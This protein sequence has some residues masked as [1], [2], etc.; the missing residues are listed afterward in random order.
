MEDGHINDEKLFYDRLW[1]PVDPSGLLRVHCMLSEAD[2][3]SQLVLNGDH[4]NAASIA[5]N[6]VASYRAQVDVVSTGERMKFQEISADICDRLIVSEIAS[7]KGQRVGEKRIVTLMKEPEPNQRTPVETS[8]DAADNKAPAKHGFTIVTLAKSETTKNDID[9][10]TYGH[11]YDQF[12]RIALGDKGE[13]KGATK[14]NA[15]SHGFHLETSA[16][17]NT[18]ADTA[19]KH[20]LENITQK[21]KRIPLVR[22]DCDICRRSCMLVEDSAPGQQGPNQPVPCPHSLGLKYTPEPHGLSTMCTCK[23]TALER[24]MNEYTS[25]IDCP[26]HP[27]A[28]KSVY[29]TSTVYETLDKLYG[30]C[31]DAEVEDLLTYRHEEVQGDGYSLCFSPRYDVV[32]LMEGTLPDAVRLEDMD[33]AWLH[34]VASRI[35]ARKGHAID[36]AS[37][38]NE[39][40]MMQ[41]SDGEGQ[42]G[43]DRCVSLTGTV[44]DPYASKKELWIC[45][46]IYRIPGFRTAES[47]IVTVRSTRRESLEDAFGDDIAVTSPSSIVSL[48]SLYDAEGQGSHM[49]ARSKEQNDEDYYDNDMTLDELMAKFLILR[50]KPDCAATILRALK[51]LICVRLNK[52]RLYLKRRIGMETSHGDGQMLGDNLM[53]RT[54]RRVLDSVQV[55]DPLDN[56]VEDTLYPTPSDDDTSVYTYS[57]ISVSSYFSEHESVHIPVNDREIARSWTLNLH[58]NVVSY[59]GILTVVDENKSDILPNNCCTLYCELV[60]DKL[61]MYNVRDSFA[62]SVIK[63]AEEPLLVLHLDG[64]FT[65]ASPRSVKKGEAVLRLNALNYELRGV[66]HN[67]SDSEAEGLF[68]KL[69]AEQ[70]DISRW[71]ITISARLKLT[72]FLVLLE[73]EHRVNLCSSNLDLIHYPNRRDIDLSGLEFDELL[74]RRIVQTYV[75]PPVNSLI[76]SYRT[77]SDFDLS[78]FASIWNYNVDTLDLSHNNLNLQEYGDDFVKFI[79]RA[80]LRR[81]YLDGNPISVEGYKVL[82]EFFAGGTLQHLSLRGCSLDDGIRAAL[83]S[84]NK[85]L[86]VNDRAVVDMRETISSDEIKH[87]LKSHPFSH[88]K[89]ITADSQMVI[90]ELLS[91][92]F[93][94]VHSMSAIR[95]M[96]SIFGGRLLSARENVV[97][98]PF[99]RLRSLCK[100]REKQYSLAKEHAYF[101]FRPPYLIMNKH[102]GSS[103]K[104]RKAGLSKQLIVFVNTC[105]IARMSG[106][107]WLHII[108]T[109]P[110][111]TLLSW[112]LG[113]NKSDTDKT[114][115]SNEIRL[116]VRAYS[117]AATRRWFEI[118]S[119]SIAGIFYVKHMR[120]NLD[121][122]TS[123]HILSFCS[124]SD[125]SHLVLHDMP[126]DRELWTGFFSNLNSQSTLRI[127]DFSNMKLTAEQLTFPEMLF[128]GLKLDRLD[129]SFNKIDLQS[130][131]RDVFN[132]LIPPI[133]CKVYDVSDNPLGDYALSADLFVEACSRAGAVKVCFNRCML[134][135]K[136]LESVTKL[137]SE[138]TSLPPKLHLEVVELEGNSFD[139]SKLQEFVKTATNFFP[140]LA[141]VRLHGSV[142]SPELTKSLL[143]AH[144]ILTVEQFSANEPRYGSF[145]RINYVKKPKRT[146]KESVSKF[147]EAGMPGGFEG[148]YRF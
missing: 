17:T 90:P 43:C 25:D 27:N 145:T 136:F 102:G 7:A 86:G 123:R 140:S 54:L 63:I 38:V 53:A 81:L 3:Y 37:V 132:A 125:A 84:I 110:K 47:P 129:F 67:S 114:S 51:H 143:K 5:S 109:A 77:M 26:R 82:P 148:R 44:T 73:N 85:K 147:I 93:M 96:G 59:Y 64:S 127:L 144:Q 40:T 66:T 49:E 70:G 87:F 91:E 58:K 130:A 23:T 30:S 29:R 72:T 142:A 52:E 65:C 31:N 146:T 32:K 33:T 78:A 48:D 115:E 6:L 139:V 42:F 35:P 112:L 1:T 10:G 95:N 122:P 107:R 80:K 103:E 57:S 56:P 101:E 16:E 55:L 28:G 137:L 8:P 46:S 105:N 131:T 22:N 83:V 74:E 69:L 120:K 2:T 41:T 98:I 76:V 97:K 124:R 133:T 104:R 71:Y 34:H 92:N 50:K 12:K 99:R 111:L 4:S 14:R 94:D 62:S 106:M 100:P 121:I 108:G 20:L 68:L 138:N 36:V 21:L 117:D 13:S 9:K 128:G 134:G 113:G 88:I 141:T 15:H 11:K 18:F 45:P 135:N 75:N 24:E 79:T 60:G 116:L 39:V 119:R 19:I 89:V 118:I 126:Y 61:S